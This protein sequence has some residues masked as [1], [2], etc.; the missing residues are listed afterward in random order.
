M[1]CGA[2]KSRPVAK[3]RRDPAEC[4]EEDRTLFKIIRDQLDFCAA[5]FSEFCQFVDDIDLLVED[6]RCRAFR[7]GTERYVRDR[8]S[9]FELDGLLIGEI[10][11]LSFYPEP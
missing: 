11:A 9:G 1:P 5:L 2:S 4:R 3:D 7:A 6:D 10:T 8:F